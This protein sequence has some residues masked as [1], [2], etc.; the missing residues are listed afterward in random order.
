[1]SVLWVDS[2]SVFHGCF[3]CA[4][5]L[6]AV[7]RSCGTSPVSSE[8]L[9]IRYSGWDRTCL[10]CLRSRAG[11]WSG[12]AAAD[13]DISLM[14][15]SMSSV[16]KVMSSRWKPAAALVD[17]SG[18]ITSGSLRGSFGVLNTE[19]YCSANID[20]I[21]LG[22]VTM[23]FCSVWSK[24]LVSSGPKMMSHVGICRHISTH[25]GMSTLGDTYQHGDKV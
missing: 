18:N 19:E 21:F 10:H 24:S 23:F 17:T 22:Q 12:P 5:V 7:F 3:F 16:V 14:A 8:D 25:V 13:A 4:L 6:F 11:K 9:H 2:S 20:A 15:F 1:M